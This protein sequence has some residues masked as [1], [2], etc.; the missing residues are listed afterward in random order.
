MIFKE[1]IVPKRNLMGAVISVLLVVG[2]TV[3]FD[4]WFFETITFIFV[5]AAAGYLSFAVADYRNVMHQIFRP[6]DPR[7][8]RR[9]P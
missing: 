5:G 9:I 2:W 6:A 1:A 3:Y 8:R 4:P 7:W